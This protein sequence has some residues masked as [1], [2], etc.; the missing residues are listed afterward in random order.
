M[1]NSSSSPIGFWTARKA[2]S[3]SRK[4]RL[5]EASEALHAKHVKVGDFYNRPAP[6]PKSL[7]HLLPLPGSGSVNATIGFEIMGSAMIDNIKDA[8]AMVTMAG[9]ANGG[10]VIDS[11][12]VANLGMT[13][14]GDRPDSAGASDQRRTE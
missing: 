9:A 2:E 8:L 6:F 13:F 10:I 4:R 7:S 11:Y 1:S 12:Q 5:F 3:D 14:A